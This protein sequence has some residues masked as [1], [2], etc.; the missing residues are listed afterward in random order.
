MHRQ[1]G[2]KKQNLSGQLAYSSFCP[3]P[4]PPEPPV[5]LTTEI[6]AKLVSTHKKLEKIEGL[7]Q[8][9]P[10]T[11]LFL[12]MYVRREAL[13]SSQIEGTQATLDDILDMEIE[14]TED[15]VDVVNYVQALEFAIERLEVL[16]ICLRLL[17]EIHAILMEGVRGQE[18]TPGEFR[19]SQNWIGG[20]G[21][22]LKTARYIPP[23]V[24]DMTQGLHDLEAYIND[25][26]TQEDPLIKIA[27]IHYQFE[28]LHPF[29]DGNGRIGRMLITLFLLEQGIL[30]TPLLYPSYFLKLNKVEYFDRLT[31]VRAKGDFEQWILFFL[32]AME[33]TAID[34]IDTI[35][36]LATLHNSYLEKIK[37]E[38]SGANNLLHLLSII[39]V[40]PI[41]SIKKLAEAM[42]ISQVT[43][44]KIVKQAVALGILKKITQGTRNQRFAYGEYLSILRE[45]TEIE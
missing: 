15:I 26:A 18:K 9:V 21:S 37:E 36:S 1:S 45:G 10:S 17:R 3:L 5:A 33:Q 24:E 4:L 22:T 35:Q 27:L 40:S 12:S 28:T 2:T 44:S 30:S 20:L 32:T 19:I 13:L 8:Y 38:R 31:E 11:K 6:V 29:L 23:N 43:A 34:V 42:E 39:E 16:P 41:L 14:S 7:A 25:I